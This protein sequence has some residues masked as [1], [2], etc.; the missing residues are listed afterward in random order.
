MNCEFHFG[1]V[2]YSYDVL[3]QLPRNDFADEDQSRGLSCILI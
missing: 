1:E 2:G 3:G